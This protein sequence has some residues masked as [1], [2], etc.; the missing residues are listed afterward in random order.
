VKSNIEMGNL[1]DKLTT[2]SI[3]KTDLEL[4]P[5]NFYIVC[6]DVPW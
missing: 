3:K 6:M 5:F 2:R 1:F 4:I